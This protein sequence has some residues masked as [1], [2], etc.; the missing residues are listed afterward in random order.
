MDEKAHFEWQTSARDT[1]FLKRRPYSNVEQTLSL[2]GSLEA[3]TVE[4]GFKDGKLVRVNASLYNRGDSGEIS[5]DAFEARVA[6]AV[7]VLDERL[8]MKG[9]DRGRDNRVAVRTDGT[10]WNSPRMAA[11]L[12]A[13][14]SRGADFKAEFIRLKLIP[15]IPKAGVGASSKMPSNTATV[16]RADLA[17]N[18]QRSEDGDVY[19]EIPMVDQGQKGYCVTASCERVFRYYGIECDQHEIAQ[20]AG[21]GAGK[22]SEEGGGTHLAKMEASLK[23]LEGK[24]K[25]RLK[26]Y[27]EEDWSDFKK[28]VGDYNRAARRN[29]AKVISDQDL[30]TA[31]WDVLDLMDPASLKDVRAKGSEFEKF[32]RLVKASIDRGVP[33]L[34][35]LQ[36]GLFDEDGEA[37]R[38]ERGGHMRLI[39][40]YNDKDPANPVL[41]FSDSWGSGHE[42]KVMAMHDAFAATLAI[43]ALE[44]TAAR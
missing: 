7:K 17:A 25:V 12:E 39:V 15:P 40:G 33:L 34:W 10:V 6:A 44:P 22:T 5:R 27:Q 4:F 2:F 23:K 32:R 24:F 16:A 11:L 35:S 8:E 43:Y 38:Q 21:T 31:G 29:K 3:E 36:L 20:L 1:A 13:S 37:A 41:I 19:L 14:A 9:E 18:V 30:E 28:T 42:H 26:T